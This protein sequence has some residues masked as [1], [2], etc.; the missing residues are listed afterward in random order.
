MENGGVPKRDQTKVTPR[1]KV[2]G[3]FMQL[4]EEG[5]NILVYSCCGQDSVV[6]KPNEVTPEERGRYG[7]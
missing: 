4:E 3:R 7:I 2:C 5:G 6:P 1:C